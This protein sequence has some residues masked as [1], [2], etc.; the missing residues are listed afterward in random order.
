MKTIIHHPFLVYLAAG[1]ISLA[2]M[3]LIDFFLRA[4]ATH[5]NAWD[6][7]CKLFG[8]YTGLPDG[9]AIRKLGLAG[10]AFLMGAVNMAAGAGLVW[11]VRGI[12]YLL[13]M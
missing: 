7:I 9:L 6:I 11:I 1:I 3:T 5:L 2:I 4:E 12:S 10:A 13:N 8:I